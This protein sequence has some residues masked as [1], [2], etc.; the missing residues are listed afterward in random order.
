MSKVYKCI[1]VFRIFNCDDNEY[2]EVEKDSEWE[3]DKYYDKHI[4]L[5][6]NTSNERRYLEI[7]K[8]VLNECFEL[9]KAGGINEV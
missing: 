7:S 2:F 4:Y 5:E 3:F 1:K 6:R 9:V 8:Y